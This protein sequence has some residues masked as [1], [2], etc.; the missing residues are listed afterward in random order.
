M[1]A[2]LMLLLILSVIGLYIGYKNEKTQNFINKSFFGKII[3]PLT[4]LFNDFYSNKGLMID[5]VGDDYVLLNTMYKNLY[6]I[7]LEGSSNIPNFFNVDDAKTLYRTYKNKPN[8]F[9]YYVILKDGIYHRQYIFSYNKNLL[10]TIG[11]KFRL[12]LLSGEELANIIL[13]LFMQNQFYI[14]DK[15]INR[16]ISLNFNSPLEANSHIFKKIARENIFQNLNKTDIYQSYKTI[17]G[18]QKTDISELLKM[19]F[20][21]VIWNYFDIEQRHIE[22]HISRLINTAKWTGN[23][24]LFTELKEAYDIGDIQLVIANSIASFREIDESIIGNFGTALKVDFLKKDIFKKNTL[25]KTPFKF[26]DTEFDFLAPIDFLGN[27]ISSVQKRRTR[28]ADFYGL[29]K[30]GG[31]VNYSFAYDNDNPHSFIVANTGAGKSFTLQKILVDMIDVDYTNA[32]A[33]NLGKDKV[34]VRYYDIGF[35][36]ENLLAYLKTNRENNIAHIESEFSNF[37]YNICNLDETSKE[38]FEADLVFVCDL[39]NLILSSQEGSQILLSSEIALF[40]DLLK[41]TYKT[42]DY[43]HYRVRDIKNKKLQNKILEITNNNINSFLK[44]LPQEYDFLKKPLLIDIIK[45]AEIQIQNQ[46]ISKTDRQ[47]YETLARK[48]RDIHSLEYFSNFDSEDVIDA[49]FLSM[50]LNNYKESSLFIPIF[51]SIFQKTYLKDRAYSI[52][53]KRERKKIS[54]KLYIIEESANFFR[55]DYFSV[56]LEKLALEA[57]KYGVHLILIAQQ[58]EH[59]PKRILKVIDTRIFLIKPDKKNEF[60]KDIEL[61]FEPSTE[62]L[63]SLNNT[64]KHE[65]CIWYSEGVF[66]LK[67]QISDFETKLFTTNPDELNKLTKKEVK[68]G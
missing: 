5:N 22:N 17:E 29:D 49:D 35:S 30:N 10:K 47:D 24:N 25:Q 20:K 11:E 1:N 19:N 16:T 7:K 33:R 67:L 32:Y 65:L 12:E 43:E 41:S 57:R 62:V 8:A 63:Q 26:R 15:D 18:V 27:Y 31:F 54:K 59:I 13:D 6:G 39:A 28:N 40:K 2:P 68:N 55:I 38:T 56:L 21:G 44:D 60:I 4:G 3:A 51:V 50:D 34:L 61:T 37:T 66:N 53:C 52:K 42:G 36:S 45:K 14:K 48:L 58:L 23:K 46:Q 64:K 9:F